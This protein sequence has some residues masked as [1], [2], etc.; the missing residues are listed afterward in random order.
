MFSMARN[1]SSRIYRLMT[2]AIFPQQMFLVLCHGKF[3]PVIHNRKMP[4]SELILTVAE[5]LHLLDIPVKSC[6]WKKLVTKFFKNCNNNNKKKMQILQA[7]VVHSNQEIG[8]KYVKEVALGRECHESHENFFATFKQ[9]VAEIK[10][11][12]NL[13]TKMFREFKLA[14]FFE[15]K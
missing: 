13:K 6:F 9:N 8:L 2:P 3:V 14:E 5:G 7:F 15:G 11:H 10:S 1:C 4:H 12:G